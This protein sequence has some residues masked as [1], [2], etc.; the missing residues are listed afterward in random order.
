MLQLSTVDSIF[1]KYNPSLVCI[2]ANTETVAIIRADNM[3]TYNV[4]ALYMA[5]LGTLGILS[6][7]PWKT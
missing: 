5:I 7:V 4:K 2:E 3:M 6:E 1:F